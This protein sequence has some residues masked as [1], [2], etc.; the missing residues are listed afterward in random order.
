[1]RRRQIAMGVAEIADVAAKGTGHQ[2][3]FLPER[4]DLRPDIDAQ[5][6]DLM[7]EPGVPLR[8]QPQVSA[9]RFSDEKNKISQLGDKGGNSLRN[10]HSEIS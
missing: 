4:L 8:Q 7:L 1:M 2:V 9:E 10:F 3:H 6:V 5:I